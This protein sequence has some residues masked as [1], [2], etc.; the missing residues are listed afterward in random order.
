MP[1]KKK[2]NQKWVKFPLDA[3]LLEDLKKDLKEKK[4]TIPKFFAQ[5]IKKYLTKKGEPLK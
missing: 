5:M 1:F 2:E 3:D 4:I